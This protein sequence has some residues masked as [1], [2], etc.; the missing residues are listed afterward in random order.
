M[1][2]KVFWVILF[3]CFVCLIKFFVGNYSISYKLG[4]I[5]VREI[6]RDDYVY[7]EIEYGENIYNYMFYNGRKLFKKRVRDISVEKQNDK[8]CVKPDIKGYDSY[9]VC[10]DGNDLLSYDLVKNQDNYEVLDS[11][12]KYY[13]SLSSDEHVYVWKYDGFY[14]LNGEEFK[15]IN[16]F[17]TNR[18]SNDL[19]VKLDN[20]LIFPKYD[21]NYLFSDFVVLD[22]ED[23]SYEFIE[24]KYKINYD[25]YI[26]GNR[27]KCLYLF[28]NKE[29]K[30]YEINYKKGKV[31]LVG[32]DNKGFIKYV[33]GKKKDAKK[34]D[35]TTKKITYFENDDDFYKVNENYLMYNMNENLRLKFFDS[36]EINFVDMINGNLYFV[37]KDKLYRFNN[38]KAHLVLHNFEFNFNKNNN[39]F[40]FN[41]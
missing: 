17:D 29:E 13:K 22:M 33:N 24:S 12:F 26:V 27:K 10:S 40:V 7:V 30:L 21:G 32:D 19:M 31:N 4:G 36:N 8:I 38:D 9:F 37:Y 1:K 35:Y 20:Y 3:L 34:E 41:K 23:G 25:A 16:I 39:V 5:N 15:S 6:A 2:K 11:N 28:D 18:Y 14:Y